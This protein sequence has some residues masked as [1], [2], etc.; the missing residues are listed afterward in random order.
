MPLSQKSQHGPL[1]SYA[2]WRQMVQSQAQRTGTLWLKKYPMSDAMFDPKN[3]GQDYGGVAPL[4]KALHPSKSTPKELQKTFNGI[5]NTKVK[6][7]KPAARLAAIESLRVDYINQ[8]QEKWGDED[9]RVMGL[10]SAVLT[11]KLPAG[12]L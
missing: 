3:V 11:H 6:D 9:L 2:M 1:A 8:V 10:L 5:W 4:W 7:L 12:C